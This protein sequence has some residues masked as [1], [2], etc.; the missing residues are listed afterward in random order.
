MPPSCSQHC[1]VN[2]GIDSCHYHCFYF[3]R[4]RRHLR[5][6]RKTTS[7][8]FVRLSP[9]MATIWRMHEKSSRVRHYQE[10]ETGLEAQEQRGPTQA[11][12]YLMTATTITRRTK[13]WI[14]WPRMPLCPTQGQECAS[15][16]QPLKRIENQVIVARGEG[17]DEM[18]G[19]GRA[20]S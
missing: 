16:P 5:S 17:L 7:K 15:A 11:A 20:A 1:E 8:H 3:S 4:S 2:E 19:N 13:S 18:E 12:R 14:C 10:L 9:Q 6:P